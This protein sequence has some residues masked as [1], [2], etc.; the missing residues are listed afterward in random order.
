MFGSPKSAAQAYAKVG[1]DTGVIAA[2]P[3]QL[4]VMLFDGA[5]TAL[6][7]AQRMT[8]TGDIEAKGLAISKAIMIIDSGLHA[9]LDRKAGGE[10]AS[11]LGS[12]YSYMSHRL[13]LANLH[14]D[15]AMLQEVLQLLTDLRAAWTAIENPQSVQAT[16]SAP[17]RK[18]AAFDNFVSRP[19][20]F[21]TV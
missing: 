5:I 19:A 14:S 1:L 17:Q 6:N 12:L 7:N 4:I 10:I 13:L 16:A 18:A 20:G 11:N 21:V 8:E 3:H 9:A 15:A 2:S